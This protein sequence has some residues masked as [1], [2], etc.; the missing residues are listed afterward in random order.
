MLRDTAYMGDYVFNKK[1][2][3]TRATKPEA[4]WVRVSIDPIVSADTFQAVAA[5]RHQRSPAVT[6]PRVVSSPTLLTGL[7]RCAN[8]GAGMTLATGKGGKYRCYKCNTRIGKSI[9]ACTTP[10]VPVHKLD[11]AVLDALADKVFAPERLKAL[12]RELRLRLKRSRADQDDHAQGVTRELAELEARTT[13]LYEAVEKGFLPMDDML[14]AR[15]QQLRRRRD[16]LMI[17]LAG[18]RRAKEMPAAA[19]SAAHVEAFGAT[20]RERLRD[21]RSNFPKRYPRHF[22]SDIR[23][24]GSRVTMS[25]TKAALMTAAL[26]KE[27]G[28]PKVPSSSL[29]WLPDLGSNQGP[30]D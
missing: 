30:A 17:Q 26:E 15:A 29:E 27:K 20:L 12:L 22:V 8:C 10:A 25:G 7:L 2:V 6:P 11:R 5:K 21:G 3:R 18:L 28:T 23:F 19:L 13:R 16:A 1:H 9:H 4:E 24:D 14:T